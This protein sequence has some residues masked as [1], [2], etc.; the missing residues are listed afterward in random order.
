MCSLDTRPHTGPQVSWPL[1]SDPMTVSRR[2]VA[3]FAADV[4]GYSRTADVVGFTRDHAAR[5]SR[6]M[7]ARARTR[8]ASA[9]TTWDPLRTLG[10]LRGPAG[11]LDTPAVTSAAAA[12]F[13]VNF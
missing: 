11:E 9:L 6:P 10:T 1:M 8:S 2:L 4:E 7:G 13:S 5:A 12:A 3:V